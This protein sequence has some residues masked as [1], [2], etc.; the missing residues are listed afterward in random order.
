MHYESTQVYRTSTQRMTRKIG[1]LF[2]VNGINYFVDQKHFQKIIDDTQKF[3]KRMEYYMHCDSYR[4]TTYGFIY[5]K[6]VL[7]NGV[8]KSEFYVVPYEVFVSYILRNLNI[9]ERYFTDSSVYNGIYGYGL[10]INN[11]TNDFQFYSI[12][13]VYEHRP[14]DINPINTC[15]NTFYRHNQLHLLGDSICLI[16]DQSCYMIT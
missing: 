10:V 13:D 8:M 5:H 14:I 2:T 1:L 15:H 4:L 6:D 3:A 11:Y 7:V 16:I 12:E 9:C